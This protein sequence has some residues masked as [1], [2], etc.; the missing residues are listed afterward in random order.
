MSN[1]KMIERWS[2]S[3]MPTYATPSL[4]LVRGEGAHVWDA[5]GNEYIDFVSGLATNALG[6]AH[7]ALVEAI[8][9]Q[10]A[11]LGHVSN[12]Y[13]NEPNLLLA[14]QLLRLIGK[15]GRVFFCNSGAEANETAF[16]IARRTG[17]LKIVSTD[18]AFHGR[19]MASLS[20]TGQPAK[21]E[22]FEP[23]V[24]AVQH[25]PFGDVEALE[26]AIDDRTAALFLEPIQ[27][28]G[29]VVPAPEGYLRAAREL[30]RKAGALLVIDEVQTGIG[31]TGAWFAHTTEIDDP[32]IITVAKGLGAGL[33]IGA[34]IGLGKA[35]TL[36]QPGQHA[37]TFGGGAI[38]SAA[39]LA[40]IETIEHDG[41]LAHVN[42]S[43]DLITGEI[44]GWR[45]PMIQE[46]RGR[47]LMLGI[48]LNEPVAFDVQKLAQQDGFLINAT[49]R[50]VIRLVPPLNIATEA[51]KALLI[52]M[53]DWLNGS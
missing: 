52:A 16:K 20:L 42:A 38:V 43:G 24:E 3:V 13:V 49:G 29:G 17:R 2:N 21:H 46:V 26:D 9:S 14:E 40:V 15:S 25:I 11:T 4:T 1:E 41:L 19:T 5:D 37:S 31:R 23:L 35:A 44:R 36:M 48:V 33:P 50:N 30:T 8:V 7:P 51:I 10:L 45:H 18:N 27:G 39:A 53:P 22:G 47:G 6:H 12:L 34:C 28:E 32:D